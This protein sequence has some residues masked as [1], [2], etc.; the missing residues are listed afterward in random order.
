MSE[1]FRNVGLMSLAT[2]I[3]GAACCG[4]ASATVGS[5]GMIASL[6]AMLISLPVGV[7]VLRVFHVWGVSPGVIVAASLLRVGLS[8][9]AAG[10][11]AVGFE[12]LRSS[13]F[14]LAVA[15]IYLANLFVETWLVD[16]ER[17]RL[18]VLS[19]RS[20]TLVEG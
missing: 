4:V 3:A 9:G 14:F 20:C 13:V 10:L 5:V 6:V 17:R 8:M 1:L 18:D 12:N 11:L 19:S 16:R 2:L 15:V 7:I